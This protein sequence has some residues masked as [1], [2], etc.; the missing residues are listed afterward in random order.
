MAEVFILNTRHKTPTDSSPQG[1]TLIPWVQSPQPR[2]GRAHE[3]KGHSHSYASMR[4]CAQFADIT[5]LTSDRHC[6]L[7][8]AGPCLKRDAQLC[9]P[10]DGCLASTRSAAHMHWISSL[11]EPHSLSK[12]QGSRCRSTAVARSLLMHACWSSPLPRR[13]PSGVARHNP[14]RCAC[15]WA[16]HASIGLDHIG[17]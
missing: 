13:K 7:P 3:S 17:L 9:M 16:Q 15:W 4:P 5:P 10:A 2:R 11:G 6:S 1:T 14:A 8:V 12:S